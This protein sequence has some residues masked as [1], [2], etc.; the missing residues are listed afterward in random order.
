MA[1][2]KK[3]KDTKKKTISVELLGLILIVLGI[4]ASGIGLVGKYLKM[5][6]MFLFGTYF[7]ILIIFVI[8]I[9][10][11]MLFKRSMPK[12]F[13]TKLVGFYI[14]VLVLLTYA[15]FGYLDNINSYKD[16]LKN[17]FDTYL[18]TMNSIDIT[19]TLTSTSTPNIGGGIIGGVSLSL[20]YF[21]LSFNTF[22]INKDSSILI[23]FFITASI[24]SSSDFPL[25]L[26]LS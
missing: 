16:I 17:F 2:R 12:F 13:N 22:D 14:L 4:I 24:K 8:L 26:I 18:E 7:A 1:K 15:H 25:S 23:S 10:C 19:S 21:L 9:G 3:S 20:L 5:F 6:T 11:Y